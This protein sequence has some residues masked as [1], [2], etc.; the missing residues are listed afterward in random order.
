MGGLM[1]KSNRGLPPE[2]WMPDEVALTDEITIC[3]HVGGQRFVVRFAAGAECPMQE[4]IE[5]A[6]GVLMKGR[7]EGVVDDELCGLY[8]LEDFIDWT[9]DELTDQP[10]RGNS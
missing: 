6:R 5:L 7:A 3:R 2:I 10:S 1:S 4:V 9:S 8:M